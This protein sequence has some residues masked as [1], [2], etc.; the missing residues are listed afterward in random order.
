MEEGRGPSAGEFVF[1]NVS[2]LRLRATEDGQTLELLFA[3]RERQTI[4]YAGVLYTSFRERDR[5]LRIAVA[6]RLPPRDLL[7]PR[8][9][10][11]RLRML[12]DG[13]W[14]APEL[15]ARAERTGCSLYLHYVG[16][17][18]EYPVL[19]REGILEG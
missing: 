1:V 9:A 6:Q 7:D 11:A 14:D 4:R 17:A 15:V 3:G 10:R 19:A 2:I 8:H 18:D 16:E 5:G 12:R 13:L